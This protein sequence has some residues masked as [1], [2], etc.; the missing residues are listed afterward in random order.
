MNHSLNQQCKVCHCPI[1]RLNHL[2]SIELQTNCWK[3]KITD[4]P[5]HFKS[6]SIQDRDIFCE[7]AKRIADTYDDGVYEGPTN[8]KEVNLVGLGETP[9]PIFVSVDLTKEEE[10]DLIALLKEYKDCFAWSYKDMKGVPLEVVQHT[11][12]IRDDAKPVQ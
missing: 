2:S 7:K 5:V 10:S 11:I 4:V 6:Y 3:R 12:P 1:R 8:F 9:K